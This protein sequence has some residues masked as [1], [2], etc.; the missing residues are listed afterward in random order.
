MESRDNDEAQTAPEISR[1]GNVKHR[2]Q[3]KKGND[4]RRAQGAGGRRKSCKHLRDFFGENRQ[5]LMEK[6]K[7]LALEGDG[8]MLKLALRY[9]SAPPAQRCIE[10]YIPEGASLIEKL[11]IVANAT[12]K[13]N[14]SPHEGKTVSDILLDSYNYLAL[15]QTMIEN[16]ELMEEIKRMRG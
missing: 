16:R 1:N 13:G 9:C 14:I 2:G 5:E 6:V 3:F 8:P 7:K 15:E 4:P 10:I 12:L 11:E